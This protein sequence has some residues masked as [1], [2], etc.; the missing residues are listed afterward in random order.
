MRYLYSNDAQI[1]IKLSENP[2]AHSLCHEA[3]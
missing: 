2:I 1:V 3:A